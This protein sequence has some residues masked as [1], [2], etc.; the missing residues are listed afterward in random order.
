MKRSRESVLSPGTI[1]APYMGAWIETPFHRYFSPC[2]P[3]LPIWE[4]GLKQSPQFPWKAAISVAPYM[5][6]WIETIRPSDKEIPNSV[7]PYMGAWIETCKP[8]SFC[9]SGFVAPYMGAWIE[10]LIPAQRQ[11]RSVSLPIWERGLKRYWG[12]SSVSC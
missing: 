2:I 5:G 1:V 11:P 12:Y 10:T 4:R 3:S 6:A 8:I 7:A 9:H